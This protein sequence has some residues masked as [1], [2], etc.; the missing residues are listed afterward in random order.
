MNVCEERVGKGCTKYHRAVRVSPAEF[1]G[2]GRHVL[3]FLSLFFSPFTLII[4]AAL[5]N[6]DAVSR[7]PGVRT[8]R[9]ERKSM[10]RCERMHTCARVDGC[11]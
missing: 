5:R 8:L 9:N 7:E 10:A 11:T 6:G 1:P 3:F 2:M 4:D